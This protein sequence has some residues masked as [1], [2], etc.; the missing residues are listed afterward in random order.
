LRRGDVAG[1]TEM[2]RRVVKEAA[3]AGGASTAFTTRAMLGKCLLAGE[4]REQEAI[5]VLRQAVQEIEEQSEGLTTEQEG[6]AYLRERAEPYADLAAALVRANADTVE[7]F[8]TIERAHA[9]A[10]RR[11]L[12]GTERI[13]VEP[14]AT[15]Q[16]SLENGEV[17]LT[18]L[19]G[20]DR[21]TVVAVTDSSAEAHVI[22]GLATLRPLI[23]Q[24]RRMIVRPTTAEPDFDVFLD[25]ARG[26]GTRLLRPVEHLFTGSG[27]RLLI[28][29]DQDIALVPFGAL[30]LTGAGRPL[31]L[32]ES[33][34]IAMLPM[35]GDTPSWEEPRSPLLLAGDPLPD[36]TG[37]FEALPTT[38]RELIG[39]SALW[40]ADSDTGL[41]PAG[42]S[43]GEAPVTR[44]QRARLT[45]EALRGTELSTFN[46]IHFATHA[47]ASSLDPRRCAVILSNGEKLSMDE[48]AEL[49]LGE[50]LI[51]LSACR[52][53][54][55]EII[56]G[57]GVVGLTWAFLNAGAKAVA[58]SLWSIEDESAAELML[59]FHRFLRAGH[60][61][62]TAMTLAQ[63]E[64][65]LENPHPAFWS[66][67]VV[68]LKPQAR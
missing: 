30:T 14:L 4:G 9:R 63:R 1:A 32:A 44:L 61:P 7:V 18:Y 24:L 66:P 49:D 56:P 16:T 13:A 38:R 10:L 68:V 45:G 33:C 19:V 62:V 48:V 27:S 41:L 52:T 67:F 5:T 2:A 43:E 34:E 6:V 35:A 29:P 37:E 17:L 46:T 20:Q 8:D 31:Y 47:V 11:V 40:K 12:G 59:A 28:V 22:D 25:R 57:E 53:G 65:M 36:E 42:C 3:D 51:V 21:G 23:R 58:A 55:G 39:I 54:E 64:R 26:L 60:D 15:L 50:P